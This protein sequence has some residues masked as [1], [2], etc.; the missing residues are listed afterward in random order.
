MKPF[1]LVPLVGAICNLLVTLFVFSRGMR[2]KINRIYFVWGICISIWNF[3]TFFMFRV[4]SAEEALWW[5]RFLQFGVIFIPITLFHL[6]SLIAQVPMPRLIY[7]FY[8]VSGLLALSNLTDFFIAG[9]RNVGYAYY[10]VAGPGFWIFSSTLSLTVFSVIFLFYKRRKLSPL[11]RARL[12]YLIFAQTALVVFGLNDILPILGLYYY[13]YI[14]TKIYPVGSMA[15]IF[16][17]LVVGYSVLQHQLLDIH[18]T[19]S[20]SAAQIV[21]LFFMFFI[22][23]ALLLILASGAPKEFTYF[24]FFGALGVLLSSALVASFF[25][26]QFFGKGGDSLERQIL[27]DRFEY[28]ARV[29]NMIQTMRSF[30]E[31]QFLLEELE[32]L[33]VNTVKVRSYQIILLDENTRGFSLFFSHPPQPHT[34]FTEL[35]IDSPSFV[36]SSNRAPQFFYCRDRNETVRETKL[37]REARGQLKQFNPELCFPL[38]SG[39]EVVGMMLLGGKINGDIFTPHDLRLLIE[40]AHNLGLLLNQIRLRNQLQV[41]HEQ[42]LLGR[43][44]RGLAHDLNNLLTPVQTL[45]QLFEVSTPRRDAIDDLLPIAL[46]NLDT[47]RSYVNEALFFSRDAT[48]TV[49]EGSWDETIREAI[50]LIQPSAEKKHVEIEASGL[51]RA[52]IE[53]DSV[54]IKRL[55]CNLLSNAVDASPTDSRITVRLVP[56]PKTELSRDWHR[57]QIID[58]GEGISPDNL[59][60]VFTP[61]FT[62]KNT[63]DGKRGFGLGLAIARKIVHLH[64]GNLTIASKEKSGTTVQVD[65]PNRQTKNL[66]PKTAGDLIEA[67][68]A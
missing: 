54:L 27:G 26:P 12:N 38:F 64:G 30:P 37:E 32:D 29:Q 42:D 51:S 9:V 41:A 23:F 67:V 68:P 36:I 14:H 62:T 20:R 57:L 1:E 16:Y 59:K 33:M 22:G 66:N 5:A 50:Q 21:R 65:V 58:V 35:H 19:L 63:G 10:S 46:R 18:V 61:Y 49:R 3:G 44:S 11:Q 40:L 55:V 31:P 17:G 47:V 7:I 25:F 48:L 2:L 45:L 43:M 24:S 52:L 60:R 56:L 34:Q 4:T 15:A 8:V 13:P 6:S 53:M 28:H 39:Q